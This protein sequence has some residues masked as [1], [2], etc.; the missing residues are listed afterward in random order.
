MPLRLKTFKRPSLLC[1]TTSLIFES[2]LPRWAS[3][4]AVVESC[5][6]VGDLQAIKEVGDRLDGKC[7]QVIERGDARLEDMTDQ[8]LMAVIRGGLPEPLLL[9]LEGSNGSNA[10]PARPQPQQQTRASSPQTA[11]A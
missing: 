8:Q 2:P 3:P 7:A 6:A 5:I 11:T 1:D 9:T 4:L 10:P